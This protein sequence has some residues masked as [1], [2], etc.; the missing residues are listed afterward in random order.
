MASPTV[1]FFSMADDGHFHRLRPLIAG[2]ARRGLTAYVFTGRRF[3]GQVERAGGRFVD[4]FSACSLE[5]AD[6]ES[7]PVPCRFV[8]FAGAHAES[9]LREAAALEPSLVVHDGFAVIGRVVATALGL[10]YVNVCAGHNV[11]PARFR[12]LL[13]T[14][15]RVRLSP[16]CLRAVELLRERYGFSDASPFSYVAGLSPFLN[17]YCEP[18]E[19]LTDAERRALEPVAFF[20]SL[21]SIED[22]DAR[23]EGATPLFEN[24]AASTRVYASFGTVVWWYWV[25]EALAALDAIAEAVEATPEASAVLSLGR[26]TVDPAAARRLARP[27][28]SVAP[29]VDQWAILREASVFVTHHGLNSTHEAIFRGVPMISYPFFWD[30]PALAAKC[31]ELGLAVPLAPAARAPVRPEDVA[32]ALAEVGRRRE[33]LTARLAEARAWEWRTI[34]GRDEVLDRIVELSSQRP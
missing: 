7:L 9:V 34:E 32:T 31:Q 26:A 3:A 11:D 25:R 16:R 4:L 5:Q 2:L 6:D 12:A 18:P 14:D 29:Y 22:L 10:P 21:P 1:V 23:G 33:A 17:V 19:Y 8:T 30:Q 13:A 24:P 15:P 28:V 27:H 20:G